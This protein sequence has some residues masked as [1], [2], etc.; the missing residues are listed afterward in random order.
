MSRE[1]CLAAIVVMLGI[2]TSCSWFPESSFILSA[3]SRLPRWIKLG[4]VPR[5]DVTVLIDLIA[6]PISKSY[7]RITVLDRSRKVVKRVDAVTTSLVKSGDGR[8]ARNSTNNYPHFQVASVRGSVDIFEHRQEGNVFYMCDDAAV[9]ATLAPGVK[10][11]STVGYPWVYMPNMEG[12]YGDSLDLVGV[13][14]RTTLES[15][16][17]LIDAGN[18]HYEPIN[19]PEE[20]KHDGLKIE[21]LAYTRPDVV[22]IVMAGRVIEVRRIRRGR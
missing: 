4:G 18:K 10:P 1:F 5:G 11:P 15:G 16:A 3:E 9:W 19:L 14:R 13:V 20:F 12:R 2:L 8:E 22:S 7:A 17:W 6:P 21:L